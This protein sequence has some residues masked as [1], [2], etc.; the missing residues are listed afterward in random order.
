MANFSERFSNDWTEDSI[1][2]MATPSTFARNNLFHVQEIGSFQT[3]PNY[4][5]EREHLPSYLII[6]TRSGKGFLTY[7]GKKYSLIKDQ[8]LFIDCFLPHYYETDK[9]DTWDILWVHFNGPA[10]AGYY[11]YIKKLGSPIIN[12]SEDSAIPGILEELLHLHQSL[13]IRKEL[14]TAKLI[15]NLVTDC[16]FASDPYAFKVHSLPPYISTIIENIE[17]HF[18]ERISLDQLSLE[19]AISKYHL[20][21]EFKKYTGFTP[22]EYIISCR[23]SNAKRLLKYS[24]ESILE[25]SFAVG[26]EHVSHF[27]NLFK[28]REH[29]T[30]L[31]YRKQWKT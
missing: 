30:P 10:S 3:M 9:Q 1:R 27:I 19:Y 20:V 22:N 28:A 17:K 25:I 6:Y 11:E 4:F 2:I 12:V 15:T 5:T 26:I 13:D 24:D 31:A 21:R 8:L 14:L 23:I 16:I 18:N 7:K 29:M